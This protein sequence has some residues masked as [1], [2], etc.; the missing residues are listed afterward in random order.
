MINNIISF[1]VF[2]F[3]LFL[4]I[5]IQFHLKKSNELEIYEIDVF[6]KD[7]MEEIC[8]LKQPVIFEMNYNDNKIIDCNTDH[9]I[10]NYSMFNIHIRNIMDTNDQGEMYLPL[11]LNASN[12]LFV[13]DTD[14]KFITENNIDFLQET[15][16]VKIIQSND[17]LF[18]PPLVSNCFYDFLSGSKNSSTPFRYDINYRNYFIVTQDNV[19]VKLASPKNSKYL[20]IVNDYENFEFRSPM[21]PW[22]IQEKYAADFNK[23]KCLEINLVKGKIIYIPPYWFYS[24]LFNTPESSIISLKYRTYMNNVTI[25]PQL[26]ISFLQNQ[27]ITKNYMKRVVVDVAKD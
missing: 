24:F 7:K 4:Y 20:Q 2:C 11:L 27:N 1:F 18:R 3:I 17:Q 26:F 19:T 22:K 8:D 21:N 9:F 15:G 16:S 5:H 14:E 13:E 10:K 12:K 25:I 6:N 23:I